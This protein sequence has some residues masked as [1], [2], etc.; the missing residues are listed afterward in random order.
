MSISLYSIFSSPSPNI[1]LFLFATRVSS[2]A[3][4]VSIDG[5]KLFLIGYISEV[6]DRVDT[7]LKFMAE[8]DATLLKSL[9]FFCFLVGSSREGAVKE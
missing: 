9:F 4:D 5:N 8:L 6:F 1:K 7:V 3:P 2:F